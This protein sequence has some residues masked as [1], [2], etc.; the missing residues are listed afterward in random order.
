MR[1][2]TLW[3]RRPSFRASKSIP[4]RFDCMWEQ[5]WFVYFVAWTMNWHLWVF[6]FFL[7]I[8]YHFPAYSFI[9]VRISR[10]SEPFQNKFER[11]CH[12]QMTPP[13]KKKKAHS[14]K[15]PFYWAEIALFFCFFLT[16]VFILNLDF[17][18]PPLEQSLS[19][20]IHISTSI[21]IYLSILSIDATDP[22]KHWGN[23]PQ[24]DFSKSW[25]HVFVYNVCAFVFNVVFICWR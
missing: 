17:K 12:W 23:E 16:Y 25:H 19:N 4:I 2:R 14:H 5:V 1:W 8:V 3:Y 22:K 21:S 6:I 18:N 7:F 24:E 20:S 11:L 13:K 10:T 15:V 9:S